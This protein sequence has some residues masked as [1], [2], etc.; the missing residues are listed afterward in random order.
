MVEKHGGKVPSK[1][2]DLIALP[3]VGPKM[4][5]LVLQEAFDKVEGV[6]VDTHVHR[7]AN[8]LQWVESK[9]PKATAS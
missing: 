8:R 7:I 6:S 5:H 3:G 2:D 4:A 1:F 9:T